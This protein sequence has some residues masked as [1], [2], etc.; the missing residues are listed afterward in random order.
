MTSPFA[1][2]LTF[3]VII[4]SRAIF[5]P[6][7]AVAARE[8]VLAQLAKL[9]IEALIL[10][11]GETANG[12]VETR[13]EAQRYANFFRQHR[14]EIDGIV[15]L[16]PNFGDEIGIAETLAHER[17]R[18]SGAHPGEQR[19]GRQGRCPRPPRR[20]LRQDLGH[21]QPLPVRHPLH[22]YDQPHL[23]RRR[24][25]IRGGPGALRAHLPDGAR[26]EARAHRRHR[27]AHRAVPD[28]A[29]QREA[30]ARLR[31]DGG[32]RRPVGTHRC[33]RSPQGR[34]ARGQGE[35]RRDRRLRQDSGTH[36]AAEHRQ[37]GEVD[38]Q[39]RSL[40]RRE[41][42]RCQ[43]HPVL[44]EPA[45]Q[46]RLRHLRHHEHD[47]READAERLRGRRHGRGVDV[48]AGAR[49][50]CAAGHPRL[51][52]QL[53]QRGRQVRVHALRQLPE[54]LLRRR[55]GNLRARYAR[56]RHP[57]GEVLRRASRAR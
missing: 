15:V 24:R 9:K 6:A 37:A 23:R 46:F 49:L 2:T 25:G 5:N 54:E 31:H 7:V 48:C 22:R 36:Q 12:A 57:Q 13:Q 18:C 14:D 42:V 19:R 43:R 30:A 38:D 4:G 28:H 10:P 44:A 41:R 32:D 56:H 53:R 51:E 35:A 1:K 29:L 33:G 21:Q 20:L 16:L 34:C 40:D 11:A 39:R 52:Q 45:G 3:G 47:G 17:S 50:W 8:Q 26:A 55:S 27:R